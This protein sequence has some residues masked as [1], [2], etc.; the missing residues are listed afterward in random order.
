MGIS[1]QGN[2]HW[3]ATNHLSGR[4]LVQAMTEQLIGH[5][6]GVP[7]VAMHKLSN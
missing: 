3:G 7:E 6:R 4:G 2:G 5:S 1:C